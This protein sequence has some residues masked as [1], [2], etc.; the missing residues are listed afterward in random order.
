VARTADVVVIGGGIN[1]CC[2]ARELAQK[3]V[4]KVLLLERRFI[5]SGPTGR[6]SGI[7][8]QHYSIETLACMARDSLRVFQNFEEEIGG[9]AGFVK[10]GV[11]F[12]VSEKDAAS[13]RKTVEM[14][15]RLGI[16]SSVLSAQDLLKLEP[17]LF[18][19]DLACGA[20]E[21]DGGYA[22][23]ALAANSMCEAARKLGVEVL[24]RTAVT[25]LEIERGQIVGVSTNQGEFATRTVINVAGPWGSEIA[26][27][28]GA[29]I[30][31]LPSRHPVVLMHRP[32]P[33]RKPTPVWI[34]LVNGA[35]F[36]PEGQAGILA[37]SIRTEEGEVRV[38]P[39]SFSESPSYQEIA[40]YSE[41][42]MK[43]FPVMN[44]GLAK[45]GWAGL[46]D[47]TPD[48]QPVIDQIPQVHGFYC[49]IGFS[50]HGFKL[51]PAVGRI[52]SELVLEGKCHSYDI[53]VFRYAR[54]RAGELTRGE[55]KYGILG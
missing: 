54:F 49:A 44:E 25:G 32:P 40:G 42:M 35:Y 2:I 45:G 48:W 52:M 16:H 36:K 15:R 34:D 24:Q 41:L 31:I 1:G 21:P 33:W 26:A 28:A 47:V 51:G 5:A 9:S 11:V 13:L 6:S 12:I 46:Y 39:E 43:R 8:R 14:H 50:G 27:M 29:E 18:H 7:I 55:Y 30:P 20:Y 19:E 53:S 37:G 10:A 38:D 22:D 17:L 3:G 23:P 4:R